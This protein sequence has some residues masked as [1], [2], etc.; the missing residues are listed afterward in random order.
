MFF[1]QIF[2]SILEL[3]LLTAAQSVYAGRKERDTYADISA[4]LKATK[5]PSKHQVLQIGKESIRPYNPRIAPIPKVI[6][7]PKDVAGVQNAMACARSFPGTRLAPLGGGHSYTSFGLGGTDGAVVV[8]MKNFKK[9]E[10]LAPQDGVDIVRVGGGVLVRELTVFL[11]KH[12]GLYW[13]HARCAEVGVVGSAIG[14]GFGTASR[15][16]GSTLDN[17]VA[18]DIILPNGNLTHATASKNSDIFFAVLGAGCKFWSH[19]PYLNPVIYTY[20]WNKPTLAKAVATFTAFQN[21]GLNQAPP[22]LSLR[23]NLGFPTGFPDHIIFQAIIKPLLSQLS[24]PDV[25]N[26]TAHIPRRI[27]FSGPQVALTGPLDGPPAIRPSAVAY[28]NSLLAFQP[29]PNN[30][31]Q[32]FMSNLMTRSGDKKSINFRMQQFVDL[33]GGHESY[34][35]KMT[36]QDKAT[37]GFPHND[38]LLLFRADGVLNATT[39]ESWPS[40]GISFVQSFTK[41]LFD[42]QKDP[43]SYPNYRDSAYTQEQWSSRYYSDQYPKLQQI[44]AHLDPAGIM[45]A[46]PQSIQPSPGGV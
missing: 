29:L 44:K 30:T 2:L 27:Y 18:V 17:V 6:V 8:N 35:S 37:Y 12:G 24:P 40:D 16:L 4:C 11:L 42:S 39:A 9:I 31:I 26:V 34:S 33:W 5:I 19:K 22:E 25:T 36:K 13:P 20:Q 38:A 28:T 46:H 7:T 43:R 3:N 45:S 21:Y 15:L 23:L 1:Y 14:G 41:P 32:E 10:M